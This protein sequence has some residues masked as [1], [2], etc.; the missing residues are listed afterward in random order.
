MKMTTFKKFI[1]SIF[2]HPFY[3]IFFIESVNLGVSLFSL[4][5]KPQTQKAQTLREMHLPC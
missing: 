4:K 5:N 3:F 1:S 2:Q